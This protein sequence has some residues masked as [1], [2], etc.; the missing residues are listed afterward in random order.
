MAEKWNIVIRQ[1]LLRGNFLAGDAAQ[2]KTDYETAL[3]IAE[4]QIRNSRASEYPFTASRT[5]S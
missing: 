2:V 1:I 3:L 4:T 5:Q